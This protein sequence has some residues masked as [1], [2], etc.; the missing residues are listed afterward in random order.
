MIYTFEE[1][2]EM[3]EDFEDLLGTE[4]VMGSPATEIWYVTAAPS[5]VED[6][7]GFAEEHHQNVMADASYV[8][9]NDVDQYDVVLII[10]Q[11][12][13]FTIKNIRDYVAEAGIGYNFP[14]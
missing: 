12:G 8:Y 6:Q 13:S 1:A 14:V 4:I 9:K 10:G 2:A 7:P 5:D 3:M 11:P